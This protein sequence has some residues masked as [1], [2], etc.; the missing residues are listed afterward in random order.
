VSET[1]PPLELV[2]KSDA[3]HTVAWACGACRYVARDEASARD[4]CEP[5]DCSGG[6]GTKLPKRDHRT[7]CDACTDRD[8]EAKEQAR[9][10]KARK[11]P[12]AEYEHEGL[13]D[14]AEWFA[15]FE[16]LDHHYENQGTE[17]PA[18]AWGCFPIALRISAR[19][20]I[21]G[22]LQDHHEDAGDNIGAEDEK[23]LQALLDAWAAKQK[24]TSYECDEST[25]VLLPPAGHVEAEHG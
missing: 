14:D 13:F 15:S 18:W 1:K 21:E 4:C 10:D 25:V 5:Y 11:V 6:C 2:L 24:I 17:R 22:A 3:G 8:Y 7:K 19:D 9:H 23:E 12:L 16:E 20:V